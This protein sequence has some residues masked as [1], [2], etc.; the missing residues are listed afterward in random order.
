MNFPTDEFHE[1]ELSKNIKDAFDKKPITAFKGKT[2]YLIEFETEKEIQELIPN[3][4][5][6]ASLKERGVI[7]TAKGDTVDFV[8]RFFGPQSGINEDPVTGSAH[9][10][11]TPFW[12]KKLSKKELIA[13]QLSSRKGV[14]TCSFLNERVEISGKCKLYMKGE[15]YL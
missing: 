4:E 6:I 15:I 3:F 5:K 10:T 8:S 1:I 14:L 13:H 12:S 11:L 7:V 9:T 2:D